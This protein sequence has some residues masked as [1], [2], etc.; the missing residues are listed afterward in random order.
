MLGTCFY[1]Q[2]QSRSDIPRSVSNRLN[3]VKSISILLELCLLRP[4]TLLNLF[5][6]DKKELLQ[7]RHEILAITT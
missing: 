1:N 6:L 4:S 2:L 5:P 3:A 7:I